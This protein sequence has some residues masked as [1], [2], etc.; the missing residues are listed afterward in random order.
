MS[1]NFSFVPPFKTCRSYTWRLKHNSLAVRDWTYCV[2]W[3]TVKRHDSWSLTTSLF[4]SLNGKNCRH[5]SVSN[6]AR[7]KTLCLCVTILSTTLFTSHASLWVIKN[8][9]KGKNTYQTAWGV[10]NTQDCWKRPYSENSNRQCF[11]SSVLSKPHVRACACVF[12]LFT[13]KW[14][15]VRLLLK[16][17]H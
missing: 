2:L 17:P 15:Q 8:W 16:R 4:Q 6:T 7:M 10:N 3:V 11:L 14:K 1:L 12:L 9:G 5:A 13:D